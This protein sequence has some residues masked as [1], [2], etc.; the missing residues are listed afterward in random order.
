MI[1]LF[2]E[3]KSEKKRENKYTFFVKDCK[4]AEEEIIICAQTAEIQ[5]FVVQFLD[6]SF[7][8]EDFVVQFLD[9]SFSLELLDP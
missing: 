2:P 1:P 5:D 4:E 3:E 6:R 7:F 9:H 8:L